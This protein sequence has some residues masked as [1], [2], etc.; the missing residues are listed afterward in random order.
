MKLFQSIL[1][2]FVVIAHATAQTAPP[3]ALVTIG[4]SITLHAP[5]TPIGWSGSWGMGASAESKDYSAQLADLLSASTKREVTLKRFNI[6]NF[7]K[8]PNTSPPSLIISAALAADIIVVELGDNVQSSSLDLF[9]RQYSN[10]L[11][12][13]RSPSNVLLC[14]STYWSRPLFS[15]AVKAACEKA[16]GIFVDIG[17]IHLDVGNSA[18][19][20]TDATD[21]VKSHPGD[22]GMKKIAESIYTQLLQSPMYSR[23]VSRQ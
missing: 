19:Y 22:Q 6:S 2:L 20:L 5:S 12:Q 1:I 11:Q 10:L 14:T 16:G 3:M 17:G 4:N 23:L 7:E 18:R 15:T 13:V 8:D 9:K 21:A